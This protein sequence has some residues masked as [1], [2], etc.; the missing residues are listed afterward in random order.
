M[1]KICTKKCKNCKG[2][3]CPNY[4]GKDI[5]VDLNDY[6]N[7]ALHSRRIISPLT[8]C[9]G[10]EKCLYKVDMETEPITTFDKSLIAISI[11]WT[12]TTLI[13]GNLI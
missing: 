12:I 5:K 1:R 3:A 8:L 7:Y 13:F 10:N 6:Y 2:F 9:N 11:L 4:F